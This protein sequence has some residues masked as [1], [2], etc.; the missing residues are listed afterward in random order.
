MDGVRRK[1][2]DKMLGDFHKVEKSTV[3]ILVLCMYR[4]RGGRGGRRTK[5]KRKGI[6]GR[7]GGGQERTNIS[8][9]RM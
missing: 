7:R 9:V 2:I 3:Q 1:S 5:G 4:G 8:K 6:G